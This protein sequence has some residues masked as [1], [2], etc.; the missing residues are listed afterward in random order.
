M[1]PGMTDRRT[2]AWPSRRVAIRRQAR[3]SPTAEARR[4]KEQVSRRHDRLRTGVMWADLTRSD[5][6][7]GTPTSRSSHSA[8]SRRSYVRISRRRG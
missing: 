3:N 1:P 2:G 4:V 6:Q 8:P 5:D 7:R